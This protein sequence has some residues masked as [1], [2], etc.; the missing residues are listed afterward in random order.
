MMILLRAALL[1]TLTALLSLL[2]LVSAS[3]PPP[4]K[5]CGIDVEY[6]AVGG[7]VLKPTSTDTTTNKDNIE[8]ITWTYSGL[9]KSATPIKISR[10][11]KV[12]STDSAISIVK[13]GGRMYLLDVDVDGA[14]K[15]RLVVAFDCMK[16]YKNKVVRSAQLQVM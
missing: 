10:L 13:P 5:V 11:H 6:C 3:L 9:E 8:Q 2:G 7:E 1:A 15:E 12:N 16:M 14:A 4:C